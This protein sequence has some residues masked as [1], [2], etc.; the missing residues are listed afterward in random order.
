MGFLSDVVG[1]ITGAA[2]GI[3]GGATEFL[4]GSPGQP[5]TSRTKPV[6]MEL[7]SPEEREQLNKLAEQFQREIMERG[8]GLIP[9]AQG[10][11]QR[12]LEGEFL[13]PATN[14]NLQNLIRSIQE[15]T[16]YS[17]DVLRSRLSPEGLA[18]S[19]PAARLEQLH[20]DQPLQRMINELL[21]S[22]YQLE[23]GAQERAMG[24]GPGLQLLPFQAGQ[25]LARTQAGTRG[26]AGTSR[27]VGPTPAG[28]GLLD[29]FSDVAGI[30]GSF[31]GAGGAGAPGGRW[32]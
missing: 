26:I 20:I 24:I 22:Q 28:T 30:A 12:T 29:I 13:D 6:V 23:R 19:T 15:G 14:P 4:A 16:G 11:A 3:V 2:K 7:L 17:R 27:T 1:G 18:F 5:G 32:G 9:T 8:T 31:F 21:T 10:L 25:E